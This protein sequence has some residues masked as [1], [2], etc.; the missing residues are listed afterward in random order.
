MRH[1]TYGLVALVLCLAF[2]GTA[3]ARHLI[4]GAD[5]QDNSL[6]GGDIRNGSLTAH[7]FKGL[8][9]GPRGLQGQAGPA[10]PQG[11]PGPQGAIGP[12]GP[13]GPQGATGAKGSTGSQGPPGTPGSAVAYAKVELEEVEGEPVY[14]LVP[15]RSK[16]VSEVNRSGQAPHYDGLVCVDT[17][18]PVKVAVVTPEKLPVEPPV[19]ASVQLPTTNAADRCPGGTDAL[20]M[21]QA[22]NGDPVESSFFVV[23]D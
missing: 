15:E 6:T 13:A 12:Q 21:L 3:T 5:V 14:N 8:I 9:R 7:D 18:V 10:G 11:A 2:A 1:R 20:I 16:N 4:T 23:F 19:I 17:S 22:P